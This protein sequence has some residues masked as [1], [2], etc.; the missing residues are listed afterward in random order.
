[1]INEGIYNTEGLDD[2]PTDDEMDEFRVDEARRNVRVQL[3]SPVVPTPL[4]DVTV[5]GAGQLSGLTMEE[6]TVLV[7]KLTQ[8]VAFIQKG[9]GNG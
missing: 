8:A 9:R 3:P 6:A 4:I 2:E 1:M 5:A 7:D